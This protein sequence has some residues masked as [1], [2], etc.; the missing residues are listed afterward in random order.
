[1]TSDLVVRY[2]TLGVGAFA[3]ISG[4]GTYKFNARTKVAEFL[5]QLHQSF[6][7]EKTYSSM[8]DSID[9]ASEAGREAIARIVEKESPEFTDFLNFFE[10]V[11]YM[12]VRGTLSANDVEALLGYYLDAIA[13]SPEV[14]TYVSNPKKGFEQL[15]GYLKKRQAQA[16]QKSTN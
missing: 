10:L 13:A 14:S 5:L 12:H 2:L 16:K 4:I 9:D 7:L 3:A 8:R 11:V 6:F 15:D 1:M